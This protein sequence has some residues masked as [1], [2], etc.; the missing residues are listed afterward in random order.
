MAKSR[1]GAGA[2]AIED[3]LRSRIRAHELSL[4]VG[5]G[6]AIATSDRAQTWAGALASCYDFVFDKGLIEFKGWID[7]EK[8]ELAGAGPPVLLEKANRLRALLHSR[9]DGRLWKAWL[10]ATFRD[11]EP[12][13]PELINAI[14]DLKLPIMT[15][16][17][18]HLIEKVAAS[19]GRTLETIDWTEDDKM[20]R[21]AI[22]RM[23]DCVLH[24]HGHWQ[25]PEFVVFD[26][27]TYI[28]RT[29][30]G[31]T[32]TAIRTLTAPGV[33]YI[34]CGATLDD[35]NL[36]GLR[37]WHERF[38]RGVKG[39]FF[40]LVNEKEQKRPTNDDDAARYVAVCYG[41]DF[42]DLAPFLRKLAR[43]SPRGREAHRLPAALQQYTAQVARSW[44]VLDLPVSPEAPGS[45]RDLI[46]TLYVQRSYDLVQEARDYEPRDTIRPATSPHSDERQVD[47]ADRLTKRE[48]LLI[49]ANVGMGKTALSRRLA[50]MYA[51]QHTDDPR[52]SSVFARSRLPRAEWLPVLVPGG[53]VS[54]DDVIGSVHGLITAALRARGFG[55]RF[56][57]ACRDDLVRAAESADGRGILL[58]VDGLDEVSPASLRHELVEA[59]SA[60]TIN[61]RIVV[62]SRRDGLDSELQ[63]LSGTFDQMQLMPLDEEQSQLFIDAYLRDAEN[64]GERRS[65]IA[66]AMADPR[67]PEIARIPLGLALLVQRSATPG[68][69]G[70]SLSALLRWI[71]GELIERRGGTVEPPLEKRDVVPI[72]QF[73][74]FEITR[75]GAQEVLARSQLERLFRDFS[76]FPRYARGR[77]ERAF[78]DMMVRTNILV[79]RG[80]LAE[81]GGFDESTYSFVF[82]YVREF[83]AGGAIV[84]GRAPVQGENAPERFI[85]QVAATP[86]VGMNGTSANANTDEPAFDAA[87][88]SVLI[89]ALSQMDPDVSEEAVRSL[90]DFKHDEPV[91]Q[92]RAKAQLAAL[93]L[94]DVRDP[95]R[96]AVVAVADACIAALGRFAP[97]G[98]CRALRNAVEHFLNAAGSGP[99]VD[100]FALFAAREPGND[101]RGH[102]MAWVGTVLAPSEPQWIE[103]VSSEEGVKR[104]LA[105]LCHDDEVIRAKK[106]LSLLELGYRSAGPMLTTLPKQRA[107]VFA[108]SLLGAALEPYPGARLAA[109]ALGWFS[110]GLSLSVPSWKPERRFISALVKGIRAPTTVP[111]ARGFLAMTLGKLTSGQDDLDRQMHVWAEIANIGVAPTVAAVRTEPPPYVQPTIAFLT[112][113][114]ESAPADANEG[115]QLA[116]ALGRLGTVT[117][118]SALIISTY[119]LATT[120]SFTLR[121]EAIVHLGR[122]SLAA[123]EGALL[124]LYIEATRHDPRREDLA[125]DS[126]IALS[127]NGSRETWLAMRERGAPNDL[128]RRMLEGFLS[129]N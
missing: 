56:Q 71:I 40:R 94:P 19:R 90:I 67:V 63:R 88:L 31:Y 45:E 24:L 41:S 57:G 92:R 123:A 7:Q 39:E 108:Q 74:A 51:Q 95:P 15:T 66:S 75:Q 91:G 126:F 55:P 115:F 96:S 52:M 8:K 106:A 62:T 82:K 38:S 127:A 81:G 14:L 32:N 60:M 30:E 44:G 80:A 121:R 6:V 72:L 119:L 77:D 89:F 5:G 87:W 20:A 122:S 42:S 64:V 112:S 120:T 29:Q 59:L 105:Q 36:S 10:E 48:R 128:E 114:I 83:L 85:A 33:L 101:A 107:A 43:S 98:T 26:A 12:D 102:V 69:A 50:W 18:D 86:V 3:D 17:F 54:R 27:T 35:P 28:R 34:G 58:I 103:A 16:N 125:T 49:V 109:Q 1:R 25:A 93:A 100:R 11:Q 9:G 46:E 116:L 37:E 2:R 53:L 117:E 22:G 13:H 23:R 65:R 68:A 111:G 118:R 113:L 21:F 78:L 79:Q 70:D 4:I 129:A 73:L 84:W 97:F 76:E 104:E 47:L 99:A 61:G 110:K 124:T